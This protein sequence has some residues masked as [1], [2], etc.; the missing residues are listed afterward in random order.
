M[1]ATSPAETS[2]LRQA[3]YRIRQLLDAL[4]ESLQHIEELRLAVELDSPIR[5]LATID[6]Y[7]RSA[8]NALYAALALEATTSHPQHHAWHALNRLHHVA[9]GPLA[10]AWALVSQLPH[11]PTKRD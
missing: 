8:E 5:A 4:D 10:L 6:V 2:R 11:T 9:R 3:E 1:G 7:Q